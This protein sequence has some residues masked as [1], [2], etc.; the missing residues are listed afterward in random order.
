MFFHVI[1][2]KYNL[3]FLLIVFII[4]IPRILCK[5]I[6]CHYQPQQKWILPGNSSPFCNHSE[7]AHYSPRLIL[8]D[9]GYLF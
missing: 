4:P 8:L 5:H 6:L 7:V 1:A 9:E 3:I 2:F